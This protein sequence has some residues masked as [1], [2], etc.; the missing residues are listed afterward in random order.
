M[1]ALSND[2]LLQRASAISDDPT[3]LAP[4]VK[5]AG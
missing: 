3:G 1:D 2:I 5:K 4:V